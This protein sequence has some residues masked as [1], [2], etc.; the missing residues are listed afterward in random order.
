MELEDVV[1]LVERKL[2]V[3][4]KE[5]KVRNARERWQLFGLTSTDKKIK[6]NLG[7]SN[8]NRFFIEVEAVLNDRITASFRTSKYVDAT[9]VEAILDEIIDCIGRVRGKLY[10]THSN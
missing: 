9:E 8:A 7:V 5:K 6:G 10:E 2:G 4:I 1:R 3:E